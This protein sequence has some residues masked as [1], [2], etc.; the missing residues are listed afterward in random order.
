MGGGFHSNQQAARYALYCKRVDPMTLH[1]HREYRAA[2]YLLALVCHDLS[3]AVN[4]NDINFDKLLESRFWSAGEA[5]AIQLAWAIFSWDWSR[6]QADPWAELGDWFSAG[7]EAMRMR[8][9]GKS[10]DRWE[11]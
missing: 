10:P 7:L 8:Y 11:F 4:R 6:L 2:I 5:A 9:I 1:Q 3:W